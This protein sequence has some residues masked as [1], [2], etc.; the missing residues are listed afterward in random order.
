MSKK[1]TVKTIEELPERIKHKLEYLKSEEIILQ[2]YIDRKDWLGVNSFLKTRL[3]I[4]DITALKLCL[5]IINKNKGKFSLIC[6][7]KTNELYK[8]V[9]DYDLKQQKENHGKT[10][11]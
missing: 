1:I 11:E 8:Y 2:R 10:R 6:R 7:D 4:K 3:I 9:K 5:I